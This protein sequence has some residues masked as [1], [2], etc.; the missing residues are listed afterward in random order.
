M[1]QTQYNYAEY[2]IQHHTLTKRAHMSEETGPPHKM[3]KRIR[4]RIKE[5]TIQLKISSFC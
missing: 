2:R 5:Y 4:I 1:L 3:Q